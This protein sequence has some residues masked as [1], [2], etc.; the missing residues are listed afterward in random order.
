LNTKSI[1]NGVLA[2]AGFE[3]SLEAPASSTLEFA[4][5]TAVSSAAKPMAATASG[6]TLTISPAAKISKLACAETSLVSLG[7][8]TCTVTLTSKA[9][10]AVTVALGLGTNSAKVT[11]PSA[12]SVPAGASSASF[13]VTA[14]SVTATAKA[15]L[16]AS[17]DGSS[18]TFSL[19]L[20]P[21]EGDPGD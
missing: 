11:I 21:T 14:G 8:A 18:A 2:T 5:F 12:V 13:T 16:V 6:A 4:A 10:E 19:S 9:I 3:V 20:L 15:L 7:K 1:T 17:L